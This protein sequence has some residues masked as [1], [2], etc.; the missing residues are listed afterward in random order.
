MGIDH[1]LTLPNVLYVL[2]VSLGSSFGLTFFL[3][4]NLEPRFYKFMPLLSYT[5][6]GVVVVWL[7]DYTPVQIRSFLNPLLTLILALLVYRGSTVRK[8]GMVVLVHIITTIFEF[9]IFF[10]AEIM[11]IPFDQWSYNRL[12][13]LAVNT[14][15]INAF[16]I[17]IA[18]LSKPLL[19][20]R[21]DTEPKSTV[22]LLMILLT[23]FL[24]VTLMG[25]F[26]VLTASAHNTFACIAVCTGLLLLIS[27]MLLLFWIFRQVARVSRQESEQELLRQE[28]ELSL[29]R[30]AQSEEYRQEIAAVESA[31]A[32]MLNRISDLLEE[33]DSSA[34]AACLEQNLAEVQKIRRPK[35]QENPIADYFI[36]ELESRC[37]AENI[38]C[39]AEVE[40]PIKAGIDDLDLCT[41]LSNM[42]D[43][44]VK[45]CKMVQGKRAICLTIHKNDNVLFIGCKNSMAPTLKAGSDQRRFGHFGLINIREAV[46]KYGGDV[47]ISEE[48]NRYAIQALLY[49]RTVN[50]LC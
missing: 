3:N 36:A 19:K 26:A 14:I 4:Q 21:A 1:T 48:S 37:K 12:L 9:L 10:V 35:T 42:L 20:S 15:V 8:I 43:N 49:C 16:L 40:L 47:Q 34:A 28:Y 5:V 45:A 11:G 13:I 41:V 31:T 18:L 46:A 44:A 2:A 39:S 50:K 32:G 29:K 25:C 33:K 22:N 24:C 6:L 38:Q 17:P 27:G 23:L 7:Y 30:N